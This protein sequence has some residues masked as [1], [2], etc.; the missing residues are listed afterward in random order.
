MSTF[1][2]ETPRTGRWIRRGR[3]IVLPDP[4]L[5]GE[6]SSVQE[7]AAWAYKTGASSTTDVAWVQRSLNQVMGS[8]LDV[9]GVMGP[10]TRAAVVAFQQ[11]KGLAADGIPGPITK[12][13]LQT[14]LA[15]TPSAG[16]PYG[17][18]LRTIV[19]AGRYI[20]SRYGYRVSEHPAFGGVSPRPVHKPNSC[21]YSNLAIDVNSRAGTSSA[22]QA[23]LN[24]LAADLQKRCVGIKE[25]LYPANEPRHHS[26]HLHLA[27]SR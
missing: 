4:W 24:A 26:N 5:P 22:E 16:A 21:H 12:A 19:E 25:L 15:G 20:Q 14:A 8:R 23:E 10:Y 6:H 1:E 18:L 3:N 27:M 9:D 13:A 7:V 17:P 11:R 2:T